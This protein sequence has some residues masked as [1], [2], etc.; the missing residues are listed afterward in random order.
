MQRTTMQ[1]TTTQRTTIHQIRFIEFIGPVPT[2]PASCMMRAGEPQQAP[3]KA[4]LLPQLSSQSARNGLTLFCM[5]EL[6][7]SQEGSTA[8]IA[9]ESLH[10]AKKRPDHRKVCRDVGDHL[11]GS[12]GSS[13]H[14]SFKKKTH[15]CTPHTTNKSDLIC[16]G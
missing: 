12:N 8:F 13:I 6:Q 2:M 4:V 10:L 11:D 3:T 7:G 14:D 16:P 5:E 15:F 9:C 1:R